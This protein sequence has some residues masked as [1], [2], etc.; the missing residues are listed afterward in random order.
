MRISPSFVRYLV[1]GGVN[2]VFGYSVFALLIYLGWHYSMALFFATIAGVLFNFQTFGTF[3]F[4]KSDWRLLW[5]FLAVYGFLY[6]VNVFLVFML[7][8][9]M[10]SVYVANA[11]AII[12]IAGLGYFLNRRFVYEEN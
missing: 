5:R 11:F 1:V 2:T 7:L 8:F 6:A 4:G 9:L 3:V 10:R 12:L